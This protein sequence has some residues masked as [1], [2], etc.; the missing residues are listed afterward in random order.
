[1]WLII[2]QL[3]NAST[4]ACWQAGVGENRHLSQ[5]QNVSG[6]CKTTIK[7]AKLSVTEI[8]YQVIKQ[9]TTLVKMIKS[10][11]LTYIAFANPK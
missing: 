8:K 10:I 6:R 5:A 4:P 1:M 2:R 9:D 11:K 3:A 7:T